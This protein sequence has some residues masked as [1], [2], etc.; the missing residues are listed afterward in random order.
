VSAPWSGPRPV[1]DDGRRPRPPRRPRTLKVLVTGPFDAGK[2]T[3]IR[4]IAEDTLLSTERAVS[5]GEIAATTTVAMDFGR[6]PVAGGLA[7]YLFGT[8]GQERFEFMWDILAEGM[9]GFVLVVDAASVDGPAEARRIGDTFA[10]LTDVPHVVAV[11]K[12]PAGASDEH[13]A[14]IRT[15]LA[16]PAAVPV[17]ACD[18][19]DHEDVKQVLLA[20][21]HRVRIHVR[22][23]DV[24]GG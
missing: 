11:N 6:I 13:L 9:L 19:R 21:L 20:L 14:R 17:V 10:E 7:L 22:D 1:G 2:T 5:G 24:T 15:Q 4:T 3:F 16:V 23:R 12:L 8:P 18:A